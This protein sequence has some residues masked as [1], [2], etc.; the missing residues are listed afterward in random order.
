M[1]QLFCLQHFALFSEQG[2][3][4][5]GSKVFRHQIYQE[6][7]PKQEVNGI[8]QTTQQLKLFA[9]TLY[10]CADGQQP[11]PSFMILKAS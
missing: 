1:G 3:N 5:P 8:V 7:H 9:L 4:M 10:F 2:H 6:T 11:I